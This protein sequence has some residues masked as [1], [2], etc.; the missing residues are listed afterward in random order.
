MWKSNRDSSSLAMSMAITVALVCATAMP[1]IAQVRV[2]NGRHTRWQRFGRD[3]SY[4]VAEGLAFAGV[5]QAL[6]QPKEW[7]TGGSGFE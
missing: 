7:G 6:R 2:D 4:G 1:L 3:L 5:D